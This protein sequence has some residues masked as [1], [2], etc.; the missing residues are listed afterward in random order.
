MAV[1]TDIAGTSNESFTINGGSTT[2]GVTFY[3]GENLPDN[4]VG[5][6]GD[7]YFKKSSGDMYIKKEGN[8]QYPY[9]EWLIDE[10]DNQYWLPT[11]NSEEHF[12]P[13]SDGNHYSKSGVTYNQEQNTNVLRYEIN[14]SIGNANDIPN[15]KWIR[16]NA[17]LKQMKNSVIGDGNKD[18]II[19]NYLDKNDRIIASQNVQINDPNNS[20][21]M[22]LSTISEDGT[23]SELKIVAENNGNACLLGTTPSDNA[24]EN[25]IVTAEWIKKNVSGKKLGEYIWSSIPLL[26]SEDQFG[27]KLLNGQ[28]LD[29][30]VYEDFGNRIE[31]LYGNTPNIERVNDNRSENKIAERTDNEK[32]YFYFNSSFVWL[33]DIS[34]SIGSFSPTTD[35]DKLSEYT[36]GMLPNITGYHGAYAYGEAGGAFYGVHDLSESIKGG[37]W[38]SNGL[39]F[40]ASRCSSV[41]GDSETVQP[42]SIKVFVYIV[43]LTNITGDYASFDFD[44]FIEEVNELKQSVAGV[45]SSQGLGLFSCQWLDHKIPDSLW[46]LSEN[47]WRLD[48]WLEKNKYE[49]AYNH[50]VNDIANMDPERDTEQETIAETTINFYRAADG[51]KICLADQEQNIENIFNNTGIAWY[52]LLDEANERFRLPRTIYDFNGYRDNAGDYIKPGLPNISGYTGWQINTHNYTDGAF[53]LSSHTPTVGIGGGVNAG[54]NLSFDASLSNSI[55]GNSDTVQSPATQ[56]YLYFF[57][58]DTS[59][60]YQLLNSPFFFGMYQWFQ[61]TTNNLSWLE[62]NTEPNIDDFHDGNVYVDF[63]NW[64]LKIK[65]HEETID[66]F[67]VK[68]N[69]E[70][71]NDYDFVINEG[72]K[73]FRLPK[74]VHG[75]LGDAVVG[76]GMTLGVTDGTNNAGLRI[77]NSQSDNYLQIGL[78]EFGESVGTNLSGVGLY[79]GKSVGLTEDPTKSGV[80]VNTTDM[81]LYFYVGNVIKTRMLIDLSDIKEKVDNINKIK[82]T[83]HN[84]SDWYRI[85]SDGWVE[86]GGIV[87]TTAPFSGS[88]ISISLLVKLSNTNY[89]VQ[90]TANS[91]GYT[92]GDNGHIVNGANV[93]KTT[94]SFSYNIIDPNASTHNST[95]TW[96]AKGMGAQ[97]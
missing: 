86:Q 63:Y 72:D 38:S 89:S 87:N 56:M 31:E 73:L 37:D 66:G 65:N 75:K 3:Q 1:I 81:T 55:Y 6:V 18:E 32:G 17:I 69:D 27:L 45:T 34:D 35:I 22:T 15:V 10:S 61:G 13:Y 4:S 83:Y 74:K 42:E 30:S 21:I 9:G 92:L 36:K 77:H 85:W 41:Y 46:V 76:N 59:E 49:N 90:L 20:S 24:Y 95:L 47:E 40:D 48:N 78:N 60:D 26:D 91:D 25:E 14:P 43:V 71:Y 11:P 16:E 50:L 67:E 52:Y 93:D 54:G 51:H 5:K 7:V 64:L 68:S 84:G 2:G 82:E 70:T 94:T 8:D 79:T 33:P 53:Y 62:S 19:D 28:R 29:R 12:L 44:E 39:R 88:N 96:E 58:E 97:S 23:T 57:L 80:E